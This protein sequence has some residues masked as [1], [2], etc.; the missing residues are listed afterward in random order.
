MSTGKADKT[1]K[2][3]DD[4]V[5][6]ELAP[7]ASGTLLQ[8]D[9]DQKKRIKRFVKKN[10]KQRV[11]K[12]PPPANAPSGA[13][14]TSISE[15]AQGLNQSSA[16]SMQD[17]DWPLERIHSRV[18][19]T[20]T[21]EQDRLQVPREPQGEKITNLSKYIKTLE[22]QALQSDPELFE[23]P[24][25][26]PRNEACSDCR[27]SQVSLAFALQS[28]TKLIHLFQ[29]RCIHDE[30]GIED[31]VRAR[32][33]AIPKPKARSNLIVKAAAPAKR[34]AGVKQALAKDGSPQDH[35]LQN[36][37]V[38]RSP[39]TAP[40][41]AVISD[42]PD[43]LS[44]EDPLDPNFASNEP[45]PP[46]FD[47]GRFPSQRRRR[48]NKFY[49][50]ERPPTTSFK[51][52]PSDSALFGDRIPRHAPVKS[53][54]TTQYRVRGTSGQFR[55][56]HN[57]LD[58]VPS[59]DIL[60]RESARRVNS[61]QTLK[62][63]TQIVASGQASPS[64]LDMFKKYI[65][66]VGASV[67]FLESDAQR[68]KT[69]QPASMNEDTVMA[70]MP[71]ESHQS[72]ASTQICLTQ[73]HTDS[74]RQ[75]AKSMIVPLKRELSPV[76]RALATA[77]DP[78]L[79]R[80][81]AV[82]VTDKSATP[83]PNVK[84]TRYHITEEDQER[85]V[86][87]EDLLKY[88]DISPSVYSAPDAKS[89]QPKFVRVETKVV[90]PAYRPQRTISSL[91]RNR[92]LGSDT[93][94][95]YLETLSEL[96]LRNAE[97]IEP[98][99]YW[100]GASG[101]IVA[102]AWASDSTTYAV[103]AAA[104]TNVEDLQYNRP[105]NLMLGELTSNVLTELPDHR[106]N[107]RRPETIPS[108]PNAT[109]AV[110]DACDPMVYQTVT[111]IAFS[112]TGTRMYTASHDQTVKIWDVPRKR[113]MATVPHDAW[114]TSIE[115]SPQRAGLFATA[116]KCIQDSIR[117]YY[118][119]ASD[120]SLCRTQFSSSR[121]QKKPFRQ[122]YP[123]CL[124]WGPTPQTSHLLLAGF[125]QWSDE[126]EG[127]PGEGQLLLWDA[128]AFQ[129]VKV[130]PSSQS[131]YAAAWHPTQP[132]FATAGAPGSVITDKL[133]TK[134][135]V[136]TWDVRSSTHFTMEYECS[137]LDMQDITF[138]PLDS[139]LVAA[140][141]IDGTSFV[142]DFRRP[143]QPL[144][145]LRHGRPI[146]GWDHG[147][148][149]GVMMSLWGHGGTLFYTGSSDG[150][151]KAWDIRRHPQDVLVRN[152]AQ[153]GAGIQSG[154]FSPDGTNLLVG[155]A[156]GGVHILSSAPSGPRIEKYDRGSNCK[157]ETIRLV[158]A[159][160]GSGRKLSQDDENP[161][162]EGREAAD[163]L[164]S[165]GSLEYF[166]NVGVGRGPNYHGPYSSY[167]RKEPA[168]SNKR[169][170]L[171]PEIDEKQPFSRY[172]ERRDEIAN[173]RRVWL[174]ARRAMILNQRNT[175]KPEEDEKITRVLGRLRENLMLHVPSE[176]DTS[177]S[178]SMTR[179]PNQNG[180]PGRPQLLLARQRSSSVKQS[181]S[182]KAS[183]YDSA[184]DMSDTDITES[185]MVEENYWWPRLGEDEIEMARAGKRKVDQKLY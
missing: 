169:G 36:T 155:D 94:G 179:T 162:T 24:T 73:W 26:L 95:R 105:C 79:E 174:E 53:V 80:L 1:L 140:G 85:L 136:R 158:R 90:D 138:S 65:D 98:W 116:S 178:S 45:F 75:M 16:G 50:P 167:W 41:L 29:R 58:T 112:L 38:T 180:T 47:R 4:V 126:G 57:L 123:E 55:R 31:P 134:S 104:H 23:E 109:Q 142:W 39:S 144:H 176:A 96:R 122:I 15:N 69:V 21:G 32:E 100:K 62:E 10:F 165:S 127:G 159:P 19:E 89:V 2:I 160:D 106:V 37:R 87:D 154:A 103:G 84:E 168:E 152:V 145:R 44:I 151:I 120:D 3:A 111:S 48:G 9:E 64:Q 163:E 20:S 153:F 7:F 72:A 66:K 40:N 51:V 173:G 12:Y 11:R 164:L 149:A 139:N 35:S 101:D 117:I 22:D 59:Q 13:Q 172:G 125:Q 170:R 132:F 49:T 30:F 146:V 108:G 161:G 63:L 92:E 83:R 147:E 43:P 5:K 60:K 74:L 25:N 118:S 78:D 131:V 18:P 135:V 121:A 119:Q 70:D 67:H 8:P 76:S 130:S 61:D 157:E 52:V 86:E 28:D 97:T 181:S 81:V 148:D 68:Q 156:D 33:S 150:I 42:S 175:S 177:R 133:T 107:R 113:C 88:I 56:S 54:G 185:E 182:S 110:Y 34:L 93:R 71:H 102:A 27:K 114:V 77:L 99:R 141:C 115:A 128:N 14:R 143:D 6:K 82:L 17:K 46:G 129:A 166:P 124:R 137:A 91:L 171:K 184:H 183:D